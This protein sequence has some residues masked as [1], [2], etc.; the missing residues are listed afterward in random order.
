LGKREEEGS[1]WKK[2]HDGP[3]GERNPNPPKRES[4]KKNGR[5]ITP[6]VL[7]EDQSWR[8]RLPWAK[9]GKRT[10]DNTIH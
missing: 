5:E 10:G 4:N 3:E 8:G 7:G 6:G 9:R 1:D 2:E